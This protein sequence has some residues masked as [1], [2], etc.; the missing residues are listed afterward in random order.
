M[1]IHPSTK[2]LIDRLSEM[3]LERKIAWKQGADGAV[4]YD[5]E[6]YR[7]TLVGSPT[8]VILSSESG[9]ELDKADHEELEN[10]T[11]EDGTTYAEFV[12]QLHK[13]AHRIARG[14]ESAIE[15]VLAELNNS[16]E[17][18]ASAPAAKE[19]AK[20]EAPAAEKKRDMPERSDEVEE[21]I[22]EPDSEEL[23]SEQVADA[24]KVMAK[25]VNGETSPEPAKPEPEM[26]PEPTPQ[27]EPE[28]KTDPEPEPAPEPKLSEPAAKPAPAPTEPET[29]AAPEPNPVPQPPRPQITGGGFG[30]GS[31]GPMG[32]ARSQP[33][34]PKPAEPEAPE[35]KPAAAAPPPAPT[36][37]TPAAPPAPLTHPV[38]ET[39]PEEKSEPP[40][41]PAAERKPAPMPSSTPT[42]FGGGYRPSPF[43]VMTQRGAVQPPPQPAPPAPPVPADP[44]SKPEPPAAMAPPAPKPAPAEPADKPKQPAPPPLPVAPAPDLPDASKGVEESKIANLV[45]AITETVDDDPEPEIEELT[46]VPPVATSGVDAVSDI[47]KPATDAAAETGEEPP[48]SLKE[49]SIGVI[50]EA[51]QVIRKEAEPETPGAESDSDAPEPP[52][53]PSKRFNP[54]R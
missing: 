35:E 15:D 30:L 33:Q 1:Q 53:P 40:E 7:V 50:D 41:A 21:V 27:S 37:P 34:P 23:S 24:V 51:G 12:G 36:E 29:P 4:I 8:E 3:T 52:K 43:G 25:T 5:T 2:R 20:A 11:L 9:A 28:L 44:V 38:T 31:P 6:R 13:E 54:W 10:T 32:F 46:K 26:A 47:I 22:S 14:A 42:V 39:K 17:Q 49:R 45:G 16:E 18:V 48:A 19:P